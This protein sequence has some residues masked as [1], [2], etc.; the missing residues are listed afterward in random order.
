M[1]NELNLQGNFRYNGWTINPPAEFRWKNTKDFAEN[2]RFQINAI[3][4]F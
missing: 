4:R 1:H 2:A 3:H